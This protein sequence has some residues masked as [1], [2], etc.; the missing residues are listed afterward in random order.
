MIKKEAIESIRNAARIEEVVGEFVT[1]KRRGANLVGLCPFHNEKT[2]SFTVSPAKGFYKCFGCD[3]SGDAVRFIMEHEKYSY[4]EALKYLAEKYNIPVQEE[5]ALTPEERQQEKDRETLYVVN[6]FAANHFKNRLWKSDEGKSVGLAYFRNRGFSDAVIEKFQ[7]GYSPEKWDD[8][9]AKAL[10]EG[11]KKEHLIKT[12]LTIDKNARLFDRFRKR[13]LFPIHNI[14]GKVIGFGG[15]ILGSEKKVAKYVNSPESEIY[16]K[17]KALYGIHF[18]RSPISK[19]DHCLLVEGYTDVLSL[20]QSGIEN[21]VASSGTALTREQIR[22]IQRY[23]ENITL[24]FDGDEAGLKAS[25]RGVDLILE[26]NMNVKIVLFP[27]GE[28]PDSFARA[29]R[30]EETEH[31]IQKNA[32]DFIVFKTHVLL[33]DSDGDPVKQAE[34]IKSIVETIGMV[35][36]PIKRMEYVKACATLLDKQEQ[37]LMNELNAILRKKHTAIRKKE[38]A[39]PEQ[40]G[41]SAE[42]IRKAAQMPVKDPDEDSRLSK[43]K[44]VIRILL[45]YG[46]LFFL[47]GQPPGKKLP[48]E[49]KPEPV[50]VAEVI[51]N[52]LLKDDIS[53]TVPEYQKIFLM[54]VDFVANKKKASPSAFTSH[55]DSSVSKTAIDMLTEPFQLSKNW[56]SKHKIHVATETDNLENMVLKA[57]LSFKLDLVREQKKMVQKEL[58]ELQKDPLEEEKQIALIKKNIQLT[59]LE[60]VISDRLGRPVMR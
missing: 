5:E 30:S 46:D 43:E 40:A 26:Q 1:L 7:L 23:T 36:D 48:E 52:E 38:R 50:N 59:S 51:V 28:D 56:K 29:H 22:L 19:K 54:L 47:P 57:L 18:A 9:T 55:P 41:H 53:F 58:K 15:R 2:P 49:E 35:P 10:N 12:G 24:L 16:N 17:S 21:V 60:K 25:F 45:K 34:V 44:D 13:V 33:K 6:T 37:T 32:K 8:L 20:Y 11:Y 39:H 14:S 31:F 4:P 27:P 3:E 42:A